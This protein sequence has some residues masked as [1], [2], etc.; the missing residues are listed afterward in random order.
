M[1][2]PLFRFFVEAQKGGKGG[3]Q[4][5]GHGP[6]L[7]EGRSRLGS[8]GSWATRP[9]SG[10]SAGP[11]SGGGGGVGVGGRVSALTRRAARRLRVAGLRSLRSCCQ[12]EAVSGSLTWTDT[13]K[14]CGS[15][16]HR[17]HGLGFSR[18]RGRGEKEEPKHFS[19]SPPPRFFLFSLKLSWQET[20]HSQS[21]LRLYTS[22]S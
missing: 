10:W 11:G 22:R 5:L 13:K 4:G 1:Q 6:N 19:F 16:S 3:I 2:I 18:R 14:A 9:G 7:G 21:V 15:F 17:T 8:P 12:R 20:L